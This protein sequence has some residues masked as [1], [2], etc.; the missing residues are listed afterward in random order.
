M[1]PWL[2]ALY[3]RFRHRIT[4][5]S[6]FPKGDL[7][8]TLLNLDDRGFRPRHIIDVGANHA[9]WSRKAHRVF[10]ECIFTLVEP[11]IEMQPFLD[12]FCRQAPGSRWIQAGAGAQPGELTF[13]V[14]PDTVS[15]TFRLSAQEAAAQGFQ[16]RSVP[17]V[18]LDQLVQDAGYPI[19]EL[20]KID[21]EGF[22]AEVMK[23]ASTLIGKTELFLLEAPLVDPPSG[24]LSFA[25]LVALMVDYGYEPYDFTTFQKRPYDGAV[26]LCE[27]AFARRQGQLRQFG[28]WTAP[29]RAAA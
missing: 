12:A 22:E 5:T 11:Q 9:K 13:T 29:R 8:S 17:I 6:K 24:W 3:K 15:S 19:P 20:V 21:A 16:Q 18:T 25:E 27:I 7:I 1:H 4:H 2:R 10:P 26:A 23:G 14:I 28:G